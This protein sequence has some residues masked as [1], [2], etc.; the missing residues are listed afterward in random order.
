M[1]CPLNFPIHFASSKH[2]LILNSVIWKPTEDVRFSILK[3]QFDSV[4][5]VG[6]GFLYCLTLPI[7]PGTFGQ[8]AQKPPSGAASIIA[9]NSAFI[10]ISSNQ[11]FDRT[12]SIDGMFYMIL[13]L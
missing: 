9:V 1:L 12:V 11:F 2:H 5:Q 4:T 6:F 10:S 8:I 7:T 13:Q 3:N